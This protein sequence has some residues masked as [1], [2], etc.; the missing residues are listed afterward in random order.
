MVMTLLLHREMFEVSPLLFWGVC[1]RDFCVLV[2]EISVCLLKTITKKHLR[3]VSLHGLISQ[4]VGEGTENRVQAHVLPR[5]FLGL[6]FFRRIR[7]LP[8]LPR[9]CCRHV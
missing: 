7:C 5:R 2:G 3:H 9:L 8:R 1:W 6:L 4:I